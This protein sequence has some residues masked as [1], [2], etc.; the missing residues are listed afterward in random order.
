MTASSDRPN[1][2]AE[3]LLAA[4]TPLPCP[5]CG[6]GLETHISCGRTSHEHPENGCVLQ[7]LSFDADA[8]LAAW[9]RRVTAWGQPRP[10]A[11]APRDGTP[12]LAKNAY[13]DDEFFVAYWPSRILGWRTENE[14]LEEK[15]L[16]GW[17]PLPGGLD[18]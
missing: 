16:A 15:D 10:M 7:I 4:T 17:W 9:N 5:F 14:I 12:I 11:E 13:A 3:N 1:A 2:H 8:R 6:A 18:V